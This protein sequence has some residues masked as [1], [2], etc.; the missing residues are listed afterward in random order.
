MLDRRLQI[1]RSIGE[2]TRRADG[3]LNVYPVA[4]G[5]MRVVNFNLL[6]MAVT[7]LIDSNPR[8]ARQIYTVTSKG[9]AWRDERESRATTKES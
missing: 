6:W 4:L 7:G 1:L 8:G 2:L 9:R 5:N 3:G